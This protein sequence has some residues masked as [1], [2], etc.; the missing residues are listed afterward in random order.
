MSAAHT[1][2][3]MTAEGGG[4]ETVAVTTLSTVTTVIAT[5]ICAISDEVKFQVKFIS[6]SIPNLY[7]KKEDG[8]IAAPL[9]PIQPDRTLSVQIEFILALTPRNIS[10]ATPSASI[11]V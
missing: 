2:I 4:T 1:L 7:Q 9:I 5:D 6:L 10:V 3:E 11:S 8:N